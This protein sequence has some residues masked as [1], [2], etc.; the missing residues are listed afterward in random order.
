MVFLFTLSLAVLALLG[1]SVGEAVCSRLSFRPLFKLK[2]GDEDK[3]YAPGDDDDDE[4]NDDDDYGMGF[5]SRFGAGTGIGGGAG[6]GAFGSLPFQPPTEPI[7]LA[8]DSGEAV[9]RILA[10]HEKDFYGILGLPMA[11]AQEDI[12]RYYRKQTLLVHPDKTSVAVSDCVWCDVMC[13]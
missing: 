8:T 1:E 3:Y 5:N 13:V 12:K 10:C 6:A 7:P 9:K 2:P 4:N 11:C